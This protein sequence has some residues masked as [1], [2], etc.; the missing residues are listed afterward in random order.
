MVG[1][2]IHLKSM[3]FGDALIGRAWGKLASKLDPS[4]PTREN[5]KY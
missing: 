3:E 4:F 2:Q 1:F 5:A